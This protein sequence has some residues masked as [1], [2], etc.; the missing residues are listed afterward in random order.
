MRD[1][2]P[3]RALTGAERVARHKARTVAAGGKR[4]DLLL[5]PEDARRLAVIRERLRASSDRATILA[6]LS[7]AEAGE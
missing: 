2:T 1:D 4:L 7:A 3:T 6:L 5:S